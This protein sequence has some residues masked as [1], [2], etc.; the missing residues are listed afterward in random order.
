MKS[1]TNSGMIGV[2]LVA[3]LAPAGLGAQPTIADSY[4]QARQLLDRAI[5]AHG[6]GFNYI[7]G[8]I[9]TTS[10]EKYGMNRNERANEMSE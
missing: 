1:M 10:Q 9:T 7:A 3:A 5:A 6:A 4:A 2:V 8:E